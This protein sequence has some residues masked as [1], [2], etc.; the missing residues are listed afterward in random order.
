MADSTDNSALV[1]KLFP[2]SDSMIVQNALEDKAKSIVKALGEKHYAAAAFPQD[3]L[4]LYLV[5][6]PGWWEYTKESKEE[7][8]KILESEDVVIGSGATY[9]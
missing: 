9:H 5:D 8:L 2:R 7:I 1:M 4:R 3:S 6:I